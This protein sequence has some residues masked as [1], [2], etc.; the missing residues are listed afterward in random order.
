[1]LRNYTSVFTFTLMAVNPPN[2][3]LLSSGVWNSG[4]SWNKIVIVLPICSL[5]LTISTVLKP[6]MASTVI[7][8]LSVAILYLYCV[9]FEDSCIQIHLEAIYGGHYATSHGHSITFHN[10]SE[11]IYGHLTVFATVLKLFYAGIPDQISN[12][13]LVA[14]GSMIHYLLIWYPLGYHGC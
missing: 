6:T 10:N 9:R 7:L 1:M 11:T 2:C 8:K 12:N 5:F 14:I 13:H 3:T 4:I